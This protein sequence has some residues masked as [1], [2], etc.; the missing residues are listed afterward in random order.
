[1]TTPSEPRILGI[2]PS[3]TSLG[4]CFPDGSTRAIVPKGLAGMARIALHKRELTAV[5][6]DV[7]PQIVAV[8]DYTRQRKSS[9]TIQLAELG[10]VLRLLLWELGYRVAFV[11]PSTLKSYVTGK[12]DKEVLTKFITHEA[13]RTFLTNDEADAWAIVGMTSDAYGFPWFLVPDK[14]RKALKNVKWPALGY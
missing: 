7:R 2:D 12:R 14:Q 9:V 11:N 1:M 10:G 4:I 13:N 3:L 5:L 6:N 8:E